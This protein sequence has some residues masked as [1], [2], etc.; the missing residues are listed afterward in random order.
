MLVASTMLM[1]PSGFSDDLA[2]A[3]HHVVILQNVLAN[4]KVSALDLLLCVF[5][6]VGE[7]RRFTKRPMYSERRSL[8]KATLTLWRQ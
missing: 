6:G 2:L 3:V 1:I 4:G 7:D 8:R 5:D